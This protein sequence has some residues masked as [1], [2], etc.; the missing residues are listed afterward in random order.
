M[1]LS[2]ITVPKSC[3]NAGVQ[4]IELVL[5]TALTSIIIGIV[6]SA[7]HGFNAHVAKNQRKNQ[8]VSEN[9]LLA[10]VLT[11][12]IRKSPGIISWHPQGITYIDPYHT[13]DTIV[14]EYY[15][16]ELLKNDTLVP[17]VSSTA[18]VSNFEIECIE[19][20]ENESIGGR[21]FSVTISLADDFL[22]QSS[23]TSMVA[24]I[25]VEEATED[26]ELNKWNF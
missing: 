25:V 14:Y 17:L 24:A 9:R 4:L 16:E 3:S 18:Y 20:Y 12:H 13:N 26:T 6:F 11:A 22:N 23:I 5:A 10:N 7:W 19:Q 8:L 2:R 1:K 15:N 21:L